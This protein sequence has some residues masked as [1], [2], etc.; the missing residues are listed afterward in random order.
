MKFPL[1]FEHIVFTFIP[2]VCR[3]SRYKRLFEKGVKRIDKSLDIRT[4]I[5]TVRSVK[6]LKKILLNKWQRILSAFN[7]YTYIDTESSSEDKDV[8]QAGEEHEMYVAGLL[9]YNKNDIVD[10]RLIKLVQNLK[11]DPLLKFRHKVASAEKSEHSF[12]NIVTSPP[13]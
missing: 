13:V 2:T 4:L 8:P 1:K 5:E 9:G 7:K 12:V 11:P 6:V 3:K 10:K